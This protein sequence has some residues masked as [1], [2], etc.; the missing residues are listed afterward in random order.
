MTYMSTGYQIQD[1]HAMY[2]ITST[3]VD[4]VDVFTRQR[5]RDIVIGSMNFCCE[6]RGLKIYG[7][8]I[9]SNHI[10]LIVSSE[11]GILSDTLR[12]FKRF[13]ATNIIEEVR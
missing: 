8:V 10:H 13:T 1:Q 2:F 5:Y 12:D 4:W 7:Y 6:N 11:A 3:V 9:M